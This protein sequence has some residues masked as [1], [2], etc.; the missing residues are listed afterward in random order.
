[1][2]VHNGSFLVDTNES[3]VALS[4]SSDSFHSFIHFCAHWFSFSRYSIAVWK[5]CLCD[6]SVIKWPPRLVGHC[7]VCCCRLRA[8]FECE[9]VWLMARPIERAC[10]PGSLI[11]RNRGIACAAAPVPGA[12]ISGWFAVLSCYMVKPRCLLI[13]V[14]SCR[15]PDQSTL[16]FVFRSAAFAIESACLDK[17]AAQVQGLL[18]IVLRSNLH[19]TCLHT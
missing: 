16:V 8:F 13:S 6:P 19:T 18:T 14:A 12:I 7:T 4:S 2:N 5:F 11:G 15:L 10:V 3:F 1:M 9:C 17:C